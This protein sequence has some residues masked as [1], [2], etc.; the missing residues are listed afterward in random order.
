[1]LV[2]DVMGRVTPES[3]KTHI[4][5]PFQLDEDCTR[6]RLKLEYTPKV[7][8]DRKRSLEL[9]QQSFD[10][11]LLPEQREPAMS[12]A[13]HYLPLNNLITLSLDDPL[14]YRGACHRHDPI[15]E[16]TLSA[17]Q[18]SPGLLPRSLPPGDWEA[19]L[20]VHSIVT[21]TC[22]Y[23]LQVWAEKGADGINE[24]AGM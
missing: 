7:L 24:M 16:L 21:D 20:S 17:E 12:Q 6:L 23:S 3:S 15:Q 22:N 4:R 10:A 8:K 13:D 19:T 5:I 11:Y 14:G 9:L 18:A 1:M 2:L